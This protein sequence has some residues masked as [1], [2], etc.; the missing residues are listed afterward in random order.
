MPLIIMGPP[1]G[2]AGPQRQQRLGAIER[3]DLAL[4]IH[5]QHDSALGR[6]EIKTDDITHLLDKGRV[7]RQF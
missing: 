5:A 7:A 2:L 4:L 6:I 3:L 1:L